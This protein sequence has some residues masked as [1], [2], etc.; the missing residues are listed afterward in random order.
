M[1]KVKRQRWIVVLEDRPREIDEFY[2]FYT[3]QE[4]QDILMDMD[5]S[6]TIKSVKKEIK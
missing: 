1:N 2:E 4:I 6:L 5:G 3:K